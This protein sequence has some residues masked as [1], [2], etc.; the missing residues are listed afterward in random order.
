ML[1]PMKSDP[2]TALRRVIELSG[3]QAALARKLSQL[4]GRT[5]TQPHVWQWLNRS[6]RIT[7]SRCI[8]AA[9]RAVDGKVS[10]A[11]LRPDLYPDHTDAA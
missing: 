10:R 6:G 3:G 9:E 1:I 11:E 4:T 8:I 5:I 2:K 7:D